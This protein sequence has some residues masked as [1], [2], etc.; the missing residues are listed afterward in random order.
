ME[1]A[2]GGSTVIKECAW[3]TVTLQG[4]TRVITAIV[5]DGD[6]GYTILLGQHFMYQ[7][8]AMVDHDRGMYHMQD[9]NG[10]WMEIK[11]STSPCQ[12][13]KAFGQLKLKRVA[14]NPF[15]KVELGPS[16]GGEMAI[17]AGEEDPTT[18]GELVGDT[19]S[20]SGGGLVLSRKTNNI[21]SEPGAC[22]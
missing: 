13:A 16:T 3:L 11:R 9:N 1:M 18:E 17:D 22:G 8:S 7:I 14:V 12:S 20:S 2:D 10:V 4:V 21:L 19:E 5:V 6:P 15:V